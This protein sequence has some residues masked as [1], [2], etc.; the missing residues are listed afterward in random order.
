[1][2]Q[3]PVRQMR[4]VVT[5]DNYDEAVRFYRDVLGLREQL[6]VNAPEGRVTIL[7]AGVATLE[8]AD[9]AQADYID[10]VEVGK[11]VAGH[12]R[13]AFEVDDAAATTTKLAE[14][15]CNGDRRST[16]YAVGLVERTPSRASRSAAHAVRRAQRRL[17]RD[18]QPAAANPPGAPQRRPR[19][20]RAPQRR[21]AS[22]V[23]GRPSV[24]IAAP[25]RPSAAQS[26]MLRVTSAK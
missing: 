5:T 25:G 26:R 11:R 21:A 4:L 15:G 7:E 12:I 1:M 24:A 18:A 23:L 10:E 3:L 6:A 17:T 22:G 16:T 14:D 19:S 13:V 20:T 9:P 8:I 2:T